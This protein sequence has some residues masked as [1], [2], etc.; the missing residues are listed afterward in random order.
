MTIK[1]I[2]KQTGMTQAEFA[3]YFAISVRTIEAWESRRN[4]PEYL[5]KL[6]EYKL[7]NEGLMKKVDSMEK[8]IEKFKSAGCT[9]DTWFNADYNA[10][11]Y[12]AIYNGQRI[13]L[14]YLSCVM[15]ASV[16]VT[17][18]E[19]TADMIIDII[20]KY[21]P[22]AGDKVLYRIGD[23]EDDIE[24]FEWGRCSTKPTFYYDVIGIEKA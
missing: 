6:M 22:K 1:E 14:K 8:I 17:I 10:T 4:A 24:K 9:I 12:T 7:K 16:Y 3:E 20:T 18:E 19:E 13:E 11:V 2:R 15:G 23:D 5:T 21:A